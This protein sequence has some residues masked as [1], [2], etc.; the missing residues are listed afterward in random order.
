MAVISQ[1]RNRMSVWRN[2]ADHSVSLRRNSKMS[3]ATVSRGNKA[4]HFRCYRQYYT[5]L[6]HI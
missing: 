6:Y 3:N 2:V 1:H 5:F 4:T